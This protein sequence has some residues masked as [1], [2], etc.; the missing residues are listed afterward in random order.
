M[1]DAETKERF[2][3][4]RAR[5]FSYQNIATELGIS[6]QTALN[7]ASELRVEIHN[8]KALAVDALY[9]KYLMTKAAR[10]EIFGEQLAKIREELGKRQYDNV[11]T[12]KLVD[13]LLKLMTAMDKERESL[14]V[15]RITDLPEVTGWEQV[16]GEELV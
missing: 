3:E 2:V 1:K 8:L 6:K 12:D 9:Q 4:L 7:W 5:G 11:S 14:Q 13:V 16:V 15:K 10:V